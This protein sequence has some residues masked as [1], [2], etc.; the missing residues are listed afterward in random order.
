MFIT[1]I[2]PEKFVHDFEKYDEDKQKYNY[3]EKY[4]KLHSKFLQP[5]KIKVDVDQFK[6]DIEIY[7]SLFRQWGYNR[8]H[9]PRYG[10]SLFNLDG[11]IRGTEDFGCTPLD[12]QPEGFNYKET[13]FKAP[14]EVFMNSDSLRVFDEISDYMIRSN[15][16]LWHKH[17]N[18]LPHLD[19]RPTPEHNLRLWGTSDPSGYVF[20][21]EGKRC[22][23]IEPGRIYLVD[24]ARWHYAEAIKDW[25]Y[26]FFIALKNSAIDIIGDFLL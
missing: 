15:I 4:Y 7:H 21:Y 19:T 17:A 2:N 23:D 13:D 26:T 25:N 20:N 3:Y 9:R 6:Q 24:T 5:T 22:V 10:I 8:P 12:R 11:N 16:L 18:F 1:D 14:T